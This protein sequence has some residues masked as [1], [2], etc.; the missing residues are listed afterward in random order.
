MIDATLGARRLRAQRLIGSPHVSVAD[1]VQWMG[2][3]QAQDYGA[4]LYAIGA[5][6]AGA[7]R[8]SVEQAIR[9]RQIVRTWPMRGTIH[10]VP[11]RDA[12]WM[13]AL[14][15]PRSVAAAALR[16]SQ[17]G[18][19]EPVLTRCGEILRT[20]LHGSAPVSR[21]DLLALIDAHGISTAE[22]RGY[23]ILVHHAQRGLLCLG[24]MSGKQQTFVLLNEWIPEPVRMS[25][26]AALA[27]LARRY[28]TSHGPATVHDF[29]NWCNLP[30][31]DARAGLSA[32]ATVLVCDTLN[33]VDY[34]LHPEHHGED[35]APVIALQLLPGFD[36]FLLGYKD[37]SAVLAGEHATRVV[38]G[39]NGMFKPMIV[40]NGE[41]TGI[42]QRTLRAKGV[43]IA[44]EFFSRKKR[45]TNASIDQACERYAAFLG[46][47]VLS[48]AVA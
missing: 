32:N 21:S 27:E 16:Q 18:L 25:R 39:A 26:D 44:L 41:V 24:P 37:R 42:W 43:E 4:A 34:W 10:F 38:P 36:E 17:L 5:R 40:E 9:D 12:A 1:T 7:T 15:T 30:M 35:S 33:G 22:Q 14:C 48:V 11:A 46:L 31:G 6:T 19:D 47:P 29:A 2:A 23:H 45:R 28:F 13:A 3:M 20:A 8:A